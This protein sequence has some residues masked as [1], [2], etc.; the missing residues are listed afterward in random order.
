MKKNLL[1]ILAICVTG[2]L[3]VNAQVTNLTPEQIKT[4][5]DK[6]VEEIKTLQEDIDK[7]DAALATMDYSG[8][9]FG[10]NGGV[11]F[12]GAGASN[13]QV[14]GDP[15]SNG[16][17]TNITVNA[18]ANMTEDKFYW[19]N[20]GNLQLGYL[21][22]WAELT[23]NFKLRD[24]TSQTLDKLYLSSLPGYRINSELAVTG[25]VDIQTSLGNFADPATISAGVGVTWTPVQTMDGKLIPLKVVFHPLT[26]KGTYVKSDYGTDAASAFTNELR[27]SLGLEE[28]KHLISDFGLKFVADYARTIKILGNSIGWTTQLRGFAPYTQLTALIPDVTTG[29]LIP[30]PAGATGPMELNW[31]NAFSVNLFKNLA[32]SANWNLRNFKPETAF[33]FD[34]SLPGYNEDKAKNWQHLWNFGFGLST[35]F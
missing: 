22:Q 20:G 33:L 24:A 18:F 23:D 28:G 32:V 25:L 26:W 14:A 34:E 2:I 27:K 21:T 30:D 29:E 6:K 7:L 10:G 15:I 16:L 3:G 8:W 9:K 4:D 13:W 5:K 19:Y 11:A 35:T 17:T 12:S 1:L 31:D